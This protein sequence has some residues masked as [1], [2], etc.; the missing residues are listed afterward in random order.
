[1]NSLRVFVYGTL[2]RGGR[3][4]DSFCRGWI[5]CVSATIPGR[6]FGFTHGHYPMAVVPPGAIL[7]PGTYDPA[8]DLQSAADPSL[9]NILQA[10][11]EP[12]YAERIRGEVLSFVPETARLTA[13]DRLEGFTAGDDPPFYERG[14]VRASLADG[15]SVLAWT[16]FAPGGRLPEGAVPL[17]DVWPIA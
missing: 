15:S 3:N 16:Y 8:A 1:M 10:A 12:R 5:D 13:L 11:G 4:H 6:L 14:L 17:G 9:A 7:L 2:K